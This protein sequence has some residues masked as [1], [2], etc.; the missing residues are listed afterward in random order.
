MEQDFSLEDLR[1]QFLKIRA[2]GVEGLPALSELS[3]DD[4]QEFERWE[5]ILAAMTDAERNDPDLLLDAQVRARIARAAGTEPNAVDELLSQFAK[6]RIA[7]R[8]IAAMR[9]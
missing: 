1:Q 8:K 6:I 7:L 9:S 2:A 5:R 4:R 3:P